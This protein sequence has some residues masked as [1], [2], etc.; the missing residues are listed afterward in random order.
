[1]GKIREVLYGI[2]TEAQQ[3]HKK[4]VYLF[5][6]RS[7]SVPATPWQLPRKTKQ[8]QIEIMSNH[9]QVNTAAKNNHKHTHKKL[10]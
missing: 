1:M 7:R 6:T 4:Y 9:K 5:V 8:N 10:P 2:T 3:Q